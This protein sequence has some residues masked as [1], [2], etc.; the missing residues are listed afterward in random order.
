M[1]NVSKSSGFAKATIFYFSLSGVNS[2]L[3]DNVVWDF[4]DG[5]TSQRQSP[6]HVYEYPNNYTV[7]V[8]FYDKITNSII[9]DSIN[10]NVVLFLSESIYF[11]VIPPPTF[12]GYYNRY[13]FKVNITSSRVGKHVIDISTQFSK[14]YQSQVPENKWSFLRPEW[15]IL[16][17]NGNKIDYIETSDTVIKINTDGDLDTNGTVVGITGSAEFYVIDDSFNSDLVFNNSAYTTVIATLRTDQVKSFHDSFNLNEDLPSFSNSLAVA[18]APYMFLWKN[19]EKLEITENGLKGFGNIKWSD[20]NIPIF[21]KISNSNIQENIKDGNGIKLYNENS[22][23]C[24]DIP[25]SN[26]N[27]YTLNFLVCGISGNILPSDHTIRFADNNN[28]KTQGYFKGTLL[29]NSTS[30]EN[31]KIKANVFITDVPTL[32]GNL[33]NPLIWISNPEAGMMAVAQYYYFDDLNKITTKNLNRANFKAFD[34]PLQN[35]YIET[36]PLTGFHGVY[37]IAALP[38]PTFNAWVADAELNNLYRI[39]SIGQILCS[40]NIDT[41]L[42]NN[43]LNTMV[44]RDGSNNQTT[45]SSITLDSNQNIWVTLYDTTSC[46]KFDYN[47]NFLF[48]T[49]PISNLNYNISANSNFYKLFLDNSNAIRSSSND[50]DFNILEPTCIDADSN[51]NVWVSYSNILSGLI[52]KYNQS[53]ILQKV[54]SY[55]ISFTPN[56]IKCD[57]GDNVWITCSQTIEK[58]NSSGVLLSSFGIYDQINHL[59]LDKNQNPWFTYSY[60]WIGSIDNKTGYQKQ[61]KMSTGSYSETPQSW[62]STSTSLCGNVFDENMLEGIASD[63]LG[64]IFVINSI[65]NKIYVVDSA[66]NTIID[67]FNIGPNGFNFVTHNKKEYDQTTDIEFNYWNKS[68]QAQGDWTG[69]HWINKYGTKKLN[70]INPTSSVIFLSGETDYINFYDKN[71]Y[72]IFKINENFDLAENMRSVTFQKHIRESDFL[73]DDFLGSIF[74][75]YPFEH[76]DLGLNTYEKI[77]NFTSNHSDIDTCNIE[78]LYDISNILDM[79]HEDFKI[80]FPNKIKDLMDILSINKSKLWGSSLND[81][82]NFKN[83]NKNNNYNRGELI[84]LT[85]YPVNANDKFILKTKSLNDYRIINTGYYF[86]NNISVVDSLSAGSSIYTIN[87]LAT[88]LQLQNNLDI[89]NNTDTWDKHYE[90]YEFE[91]SKNEIIVENIIDWNNEQTSLNRNISSNEKWIQENGIMETIFSYY[92]YKGFGLI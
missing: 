59:C 67:F 66:K 71:P 89:N 90:F 80:N 41:I 45:P 53:G 37:S 17:L 60:Q 82:Y 56:Q 30:A 50:F 47:G 12:S 15:R 58:R 40:I 79:N 49:S 91:D 27:S 61:L 46:L 23:I 52:I 32:T 22:Y 70:F 85:S 18:I 24:H 88:L 83:I 42:K 81:N 20:S 21:T 55:P 6:N 51:D 57:S 64:R 38:A 10:I 35:S 54:I 84:T 13:P 31:V 75:K 16:D 78:S 11:D 3:Y 19:P 26:K 65:E 62:T 86:K 8:K 36:Y 28:F 87:D 43:N 74:G 33:H 92:L 68:A 29:T 1:I 39:S 76:D 44:S 69:F 48:V 77:A 73:F 9:S 4:G 2:F 7:S 72:E 25:F 34:L 14:S 5:N 63:I